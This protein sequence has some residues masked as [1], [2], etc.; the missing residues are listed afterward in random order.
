MGPE[1]PQ[2]RPQLAPPLL[3][4]SQEG[5]GRRRL[6]SRPSQPNGAT[7]APALALPPPLL[8]AVVAGALSQSARQEGGVVGRGPRE[9]V[10]SRGRLLPLVPLTALGPAGGADGGPAPPAVPAAVAVGAAEVSAV[11]SAVDSAEGLGQRRGAWVGPVGT[12]GGRG[13]WGMAPCAS[14]WAPGGRAEEG[15]KLRDASGLRDVREGGREA[16]V[17]RARRRNGRVELS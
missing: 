14:A 9:P 7:P 16:G 13:W 12:R 17:Q 11:D 10:G 8:R 6:G 1:L 3:Q 5:Q 4:R 2:R 15:V